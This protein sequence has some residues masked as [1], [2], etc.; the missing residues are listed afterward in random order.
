M[1]TQV[2]ERQRDG[3]REED[4]RRGSFHAV[5]ERRGKE[6]RLGAGGGGG[7]E[8]EV[9]TSLCSALE[10]MIESGFYF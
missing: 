3:V 8:G 7:G 10:D 5:A 4:E 6:L 1:R 9:G 2:G